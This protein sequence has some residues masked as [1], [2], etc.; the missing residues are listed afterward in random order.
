MK[1]N[2]LITLLA[3][4][5]LLI[6][7]QPAFPQTTVAPDRGNAAPREALPHDL[8]DLEV[9]DFYIDSDAQHAGFIQTVIGHVIVLHEDSRQAFF[10]AAGDAVFK[11]D[12]IFTLAD[13]RCRLKFTTE[14]VITMGDNTRL[15]LEEY[16]DNRPE[17]KKTSIF[18]M[19]RGKAMFYA[20]RL[21]KYRTAAT[22]VKTPTAV[23]GVRGTKFGVEIRKAGENIAAGRPVYL[24][25][26]SDAGLQHLLAQFSPGGWVTLALC[27]TGAIDVTALADNTTQTLYENE[28]RAAGPE[29][30]EN[31][32]PT[33]PDAAQ[34]F[35][36]ATEAPE[37]GA[38]AKE[39]GKKGEGTP[40]GGVA[41]VSVVDTGAAGT[42]ET[43]LANKAED[44][45]S[46]QT[47]VKIETA[48][49]VRKGY[50]TGMLTLDNGVSKNFS[51]LYLSPSLQYTQFQPAKAHD[52]LIGKDL[53][54]DDI[55]QTDT[56]KITGLGI[57]APYAV[58]GFPYPI[59]TVDLG[60]NAYMEWGYWTQTQ[61]MPAT[62]GNSY[63]FDNRGYWIFG[64]IPSESTM[65]LLKANNISG[66]YN[67]T[68]FGTYWTSTGGADMSGSF[69]AAINFGAAVPITNFEL[70]ISG[71]DHTVKI[72][73]AEGQFTDPQNSS[74]FVLPS[75][76]AN[77]TWKID[78][79]EADAGTYTKNAYGSV[80]G[81]N[82]EAMG[83]VWKIDASGTHAT[84][85]FQGVR[86]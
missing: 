74:H 39:E 85:I 42:A 70:Y 6:A 69:S 25:A 60:S 2:I 14:D 72:S 37:P 48:G 71:N 80:Y 1:Q 21:F 73:G 13:S 32:Q 55:N 24:A 19:L 53:V 52:S 29:G 64:D 41:V 51:Y 75:G 77:G 35:E 30:G 81:P 57:P 10:A 43:K 50:F 58:S 63:Y 45:T 27:F 78:G 23:V 33:S 59:Q 31:K 54:V 38:A 68:A 28:S 7:K 3:L 65:S 83:G 20:M 40:A 67:G 9:K 79:V 86:Q 18:N 76:G 26:A 17:K 36:S 34:Q 12:S 11:H 4:T 15:G 22:A 61:A 8:R 56:Q 49:T 44:V 62:D 5:C 66:I 16:I 84:G 82:A 47:D 46:K